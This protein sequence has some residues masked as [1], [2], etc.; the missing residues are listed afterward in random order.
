MLPNANEYVGHLKQY[1][2]FLDTARFMCNDLGINFQSK[3][4]EREKSSH[5]STYSIYVEGIY[6]L[7]FLLDTTVTTN[8]V[9]KT[10]V[11]VD[12]RY[13]G[14]SASFHV[15]D[16]ITEHTNKDGYLERW[17]TKTMHDFK[18]KHYPVN[19]DALF[20]TAG[21]RVYGTYID[22]HLALK[23]MKLLLNG[24]QF[25]KMNKPIVYRFRHVD[26]HFIRTYSYG[27]FVSND[28]N[29]DFW[30]FFHNM[31]GQDS[32]SRAFTLKRADTMIA[33]NPTTDLR[34]HDIEYD[35]FRRFL[36]ENVTTFNYVGKNALSFDVYPGQENFGETFSESY[37]KFLE[38]YYNRE[39]SQALRDLRALL[40][41]AMEIV[42][43][44]KKITIPEKP[45]IYDLC[46]RLVKNKIL[47]G[48]TTE[49]YRA[50]SSVANSAAH[51]E[52]PTK[53]D[54]LNQNVKNR[55]KMAI[56]LGTHLI[57]ELDDALD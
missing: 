34:L 56:L 30:A 52:F 8:K 32:D 35:K 16:D 7:Y 42:C 15:S 47:D 55:T 12:I 40:Q 11:T 37:S 18:L 26:G 54:L 53:D 57:G 46:L 2:L 25:A 38:R 36:S 20:G 48:K 28:Y 17:A 45:K 43:E 21:I 51:G 23:E 49:W 13:D 19:L 33:S 29:P 44:K 6:T 14:G 31:G 50:F 4:I 22:P 3:K 5:G 39:Y 41:M 27:F 1:G 24:M 9:Q 10:E